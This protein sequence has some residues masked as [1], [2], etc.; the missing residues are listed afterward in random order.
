MTP[1]TPRTEPKRFAL[2]ASPD[3]RRVAV[4]GI[5]IAYGDRGD[6]F[7][8]IGLHA[9]TH[10]SRDF[11]HV[12]GTLAARWRFITPDWPGQ[13]RSGVDQHPARLARYTALLAG[14]MDA[15]KIDR[16][17]LIGNSIGGSAAMAYAAESPGR[18]AGLVLADPGGLIPMNALGYRICGMMAALGRAGQRDAFYFKPVFAT[19]YRQFLRTPAA[20]EQR[21]RIVEAA[22]ECASIWEQAWLGFRT[23]EADQTGIGAQIN[24]PVLFTWASRDPI[25]SFAR[26][27]DAIARF[28]NHSV[29]L[30]GGGHCPFLEEPEKFFAAV[31]PFIE[32]ATNGIKSERP[33]AAAAR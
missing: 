12:A 7:P 8:I 18:V 16:A 33:L 22:A 28:P 24:C 13:G 3:C 32:K 19:M 11:E 26:S 6:G 23:P 29:A 17:I 30:F 9:I 14:F 31:E 21:D 4:D 2:G 25:V 15:L 27:K 20:R 10:G 1:A 5:S